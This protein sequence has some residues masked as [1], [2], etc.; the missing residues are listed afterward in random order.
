MP[1]KERTMKHLAI[2]ADTS[3]E[4]AWV[5]VQAFRSMP[6]QKRLRMV[7]EL[8][9]SLRSIVAAGVRSRHPEFTAEQVKLEV[10]RLTLGEELFRKVYSRQ[11]T[12]RCPKRNFSPR[13]R[14]CWRRPASPT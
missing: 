5:Q 1:A 8:S 12:A 13:L 11:E 7:F 14:S 4:A 6:A 2:P 10:I 9:D 3:P